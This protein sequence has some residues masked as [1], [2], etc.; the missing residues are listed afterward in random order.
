MVN[1]DYQNTDIAD[2]LELR[3][4]LWQP[5]FGLLYMG[6]TLDPPGEYD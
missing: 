1:K 4:L 3:M 2:T 5:V 6:I